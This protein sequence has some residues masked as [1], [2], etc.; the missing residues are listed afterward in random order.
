MPDHKALIRDE[1]TRQ[2]PAYAA[3]PLIADPERVA[4]L[5]ATVAPRAEDRVLEVATGPG[6]VA[7]G[8]AAVCRE[9]VGIDLTEA[10][11]AIAEQTRRE[12]GLENVRFQTADAE[13]LPFADGE[14]DVVVCRFAFHHFEDPPRVLREMTRVCRLGG[15]VAVQDVIVSEFARRAAYH[16]RFENLRDPSH[17]RAFPLSELLRVFTV[18]G[19]EVERIATSEMLQPVELWMQR[20]QTP[21]DKASEV[22]ALIE[23]DEQDD[24]SGTRPFRRDGDLSFRQT[25]AILA[26]RRLQ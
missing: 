1:F 3:N 17:T 4:R 13:K 2:A 25:L 23:R 10:P 24:L 19:L 16:N 20:A 26:A 22:R 14:F 7:L 8:F 18:T 21:P 15:T 6:Y 11:L 5:V 9:V 12:R